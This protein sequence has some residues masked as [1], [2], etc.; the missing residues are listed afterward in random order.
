MFG[1]SGATSSAKRGILGLITKRGYAV[2]ND[3]LF[4]NH[5]N[6]GLIWY[7]AGEDNCPCSVNTR[8][9]YT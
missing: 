4:E 6:F 1:S 3:G 9:A 7:R 8:G 5:L 2:S